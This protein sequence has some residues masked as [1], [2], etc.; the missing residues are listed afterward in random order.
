[1]KRRSLRCNRDRGFA[2]VAA[3]FLMVVLAGLG[4]FAVRTAM[5]QQF[6]TNL[7]LDSAKAEA[8]VQAGMEY[9]A[10]RLSPSNG[11]ASLSTPFAVADGFTV[12]IDNCAQQNPAPMVNGVAL[13][14]FTFDITASRGTYG[15]PEFVSRTQSVRV[16]P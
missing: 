12:R 5:S 1:M 9:A 16:A 4:A 8:A 13:S 2:L 15:S 7:E 3:I 6:V 10:F 14:V 11:C